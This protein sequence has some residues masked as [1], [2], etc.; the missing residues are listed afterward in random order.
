MIGRLKDTL[1]SQKHILYILLFAGLAL[2]ILLTSFVYVYNTIYENETA[3]KNEDIQNIEEVYKWNF[4][5]SLI[6]STRDTAKLNSE[7]IRGEIEHELRLQY[8]GEMDQLKYDIDNLTSSSRFSKILNNSIDGEYIV[9]QNDNND[10]SIGVIKYGIYSDKSEN[11]SIE[12]GE[13][14]SWANE[15]DSHANKKL[16]EQAIETFKNI[17][18][19]STKLIFWEYLESRDEDHIMIENM[20]ERELKR[21]FL[22]EGLYGLQTYEF[23]SFSFIDDN[24]T[25]VF[26]KFDVGNLGVRND[27]YKII[28][29]Q[30]FNIVDLIRTKYKDQLKEFDYMKQL[31]I[32]EYNNKVAT[33]R[34]LLTL[35]TL[36]AS[37]FFISIVNIYNG[38]I[39]GMDI[40]D[41]KNNINWKFIDP[42]LKEK[43]V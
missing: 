43:G 9:V 8:D 6:T 14:R 40:T 37:I 33:S 34:I 39:T 19:S 3:R 32:K 27:N 10:P 42:Q 11:Y 26:G 24:G 36:I 41:E 38:I 20:S 30:G 2:L 4:I 22:E 7:K 35:M 16:A 17:E 31:R 28:V 23:L 15:I 25:D 21:V 18:N 29:I 12:E 13:K 1:K 5:R